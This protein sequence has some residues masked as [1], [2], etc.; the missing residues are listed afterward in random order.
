MAHK[1][2]EPFPLSGKEY[3]VLFVGKIENIGGKTDLN[4]SNLL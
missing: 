4:D 3:T 1:T 2:Y